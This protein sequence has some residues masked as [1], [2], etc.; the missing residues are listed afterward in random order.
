MAAHFA[1][2]QYMY[3]DIQL[4]SRQRAASMLV[5]LVFCIGYPT[6]VVSAGYI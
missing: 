5:H 4:D 2:M 3:E 1:V 6:V